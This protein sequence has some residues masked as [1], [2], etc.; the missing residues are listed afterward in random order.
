MP[1]KHIEE[2]LLD[3]YALGSLSAESIAELEEHL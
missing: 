3:Q 1:M 2:N